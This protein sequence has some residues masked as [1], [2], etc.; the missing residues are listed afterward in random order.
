MGLQKL[1]LLGVLESIKN[2]F[3]EEESHTTCSQPSPPGAAVTSE[4][5]D[6]L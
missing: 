3:V 6:L 1:R 2:V 5:V 4:I